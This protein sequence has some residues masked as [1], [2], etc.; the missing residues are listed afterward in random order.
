MENVMKKVSVI[1]LFLLLSTSLSL[2]AQRRMD[3]KEQIKEL[4][5]E[6]K[7]TDKQADSIKVVLDEMRDTMSKMRDDADGDWSG[8]REKMRELRDKTT[9]KIEKYLTEEQVVKYKKL[10]EEQD[11][12]RQKRFGNRR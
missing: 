6:L 9:K 8:M 10:L 5:S 12:E 1:V 3:T 11:K 4:K 2:M 7:L